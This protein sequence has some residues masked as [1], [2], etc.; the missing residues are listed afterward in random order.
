MVNAN[1]PRLVSKHGDEVR[2]PNGCPHC[3]G[4]VDVKVIG[5]SARS[6]CLSCQLISMA[7]VQH[8]PGGVLIDF[9][10]GGAQ[11]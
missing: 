8:Q 4:P 3:G 1:G 5:S 7:T 11:A 2:L 10:G 6:V 9:R